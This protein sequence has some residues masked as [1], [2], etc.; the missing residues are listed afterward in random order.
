MSL[1]VA[2]GFHRAWV[3]SWVSQATV[4]M[5]LL[6]HAGAPS[7]GMSRAAHRPKLIGWGLVRP[8]CAAAAAAASASASSAGD[9]PVAS[10]VTSAYL[11]PFPVQGGQQGLLSTDRGPVGG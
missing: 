5:R 1:V 3:Y 6:V 4:T 7:R 11:P 10:R 9:S 2:S 8:S